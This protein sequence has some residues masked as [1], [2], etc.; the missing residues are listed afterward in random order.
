MMLFAPP[1]LGHR[2]RLPGGVLAKSC[3]IRSGADMLVFHT[4]LSLLHDP[5]HEILSGC[6]QPYFES[7][8]R[9]SRILSTLLDT[10]SSDHQS[11]EERCCDWTRHDVAADA[12]LLAA[13]A[14]VHDTSYLDFLREIYA[15][16]IAEGGSRVRFSR[17]RSAPP[18]PAHVS[19]NGDQC[20]TQ[21][22]ALPETFLR[23]DMLLEPDLPDLTS[24]GSAIARI[25]Q[26]AFVSQMYDHPR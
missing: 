18:R 14:R 6:A 2:R 25:G 12:P 20:S 24:S 13:V 15:E 4:P 11:F 7:P 1:L 17:M 3:L 23:R 10:S 9:V 22:A 26:L 5:P 16:W 19:A 8:D 21:D